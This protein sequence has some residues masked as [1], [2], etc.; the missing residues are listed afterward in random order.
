MASSIIE[1]PQLQQV[2]RGGDNDTPFI[3][4]QNAAQASPLHYDS[5]GPGAAVLQTL[6]PVDGGR[7]AW[8]F[9]LGCFMLDGIVWGEHR[10]RMPTCARNNMLNILQGSHC[11][12]ESSKYIIAPTSHSRTSPAKALALQPLVRQRPASHTSQA[13]SLVSS[14]NVILT[15]AGQPCTRG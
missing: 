3:D 14:C 6:P 5:S 4:T 9:L 2:H 10:D 13:L 7:R 11:L 8:L 1:L 15:P 12:L